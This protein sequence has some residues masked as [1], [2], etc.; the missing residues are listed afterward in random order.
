M[1]PNIFVITALALAVGVLVSV[2]PQRESKIRAVPV[3]IRLLEHGIQ[4]V[5][6]PLNF[7]VRRCW[8][9]WGRRA[10][11]LFVMDFR[12]KLEVCGDG[13]SNV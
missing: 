6:S 12:I 10:R 11:A 4:M 2:F 1:L 13:G 3:T 9:H 5:L 8:D 7:S